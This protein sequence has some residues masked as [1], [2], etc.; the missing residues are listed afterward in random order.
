MNKRR[1]VITGLGAVTPCGIGTD[2]FWNAMLEGKSGISLIERIDTEKQDVKIADEIKDATYSCYD[3]ACGTGGMLT[4]AQDRLMTLE[5]RRNK[6]EH[7]SSLQIGAGSIQLID[8]L[9]SWT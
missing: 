1:V 3:G 8:T 7:I 9:Y 6:E 4:V 2:N 5:K